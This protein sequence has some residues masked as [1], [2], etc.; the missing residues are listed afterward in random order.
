LTK[1]DLWSTNQEHWSNPVCS[2]LVLCRRQQ[3]GGGCDRHE[4]HSGGNH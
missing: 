2:A 4:D 1:P 3:R